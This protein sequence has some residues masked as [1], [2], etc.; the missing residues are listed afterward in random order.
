MGKFKF[1]PVLLCLPVLFGCSAEGNID[2]KDKDNDKEKINVVCTIFP[3]YDWA[4]EIALNTDNADITLMAD[5]GTDFH[6]YQPS[7]QDI[8]TVSSCDVLIYAGG[9]SDKWI[10]DALKN[11]SNPKMQAVKLSD[12]ISD[13]LLSEPE[14]HSSDHDHDHEHEEH[15]FDEHVWLSL[16]NAAA[17]TDAI[18]EAFCKADEGNADLYR[19]NADDYKLKLTEM[20]GEFEE[21]V[22]NAK[23]N[24][25]LFGDRFPFVYLMNDY[26]IE[27][28]AAFPGCSSEIDASFDMVVS[29]A[30][31]VDREELPVVLTIEDSNSNIADAIIS[32][33]KNKDQK[34]LT[35]DSMQIVRRE[36]I[37]KG[38]TY[39][40]VME[41]NLDVLSEALG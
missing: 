22:R 10:D 11:K 13:S 19:K 12:V 33:T 30:E 7:T 5:N 38:K 21:T 8:V 6:S 3:E 25:V 31:E 18:T 26:G 15:V 24:T 27:Y 14:T 4:R 37:D 23:R 29:L 39:L 17:F 40:S 36:E 1:L 35:L 32:N 41:K 28:Y 2:D 16:K 34:V 9:Q 20:D